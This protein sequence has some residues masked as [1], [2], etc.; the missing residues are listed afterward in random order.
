[1]TN[2]YDFLQ[3]QPTA[4]QGEIETALETR[5]HQ[6]RKLVTHHDPQVANQATQALTVLEQARVTLLDPGKRTAYDTGIGLNSVLGGLADPEAILQKLDAARVLPP[7]PKSPTTQGLVDVLKCPHC[8]N[9]SNP[10]DARF[11]LSCRYPLTQICPNPECKS[12]LPLNYRNC[13]RCGR[14]IEEERRNQ[15]QLTVQAEANLQQEIRGVI[16]QVQALL[17]EKKWRVARE[18]LAC[19]E[20]L[21]VPTN[22]DKQPGPDPIYSQGRPEWQMASELDQSAN[23]MKQGLI[24]SLILWM[25]GVYGILGLIGG[26]IAEPSAPESALF[27]GLFL[28]VAAAIGSGIYAY[29]WSGRYGGTSDYVLGGLAPLVLLLGFWLVIILIVLWFAGIALGGG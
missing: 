29:K 3:V 4:S 13:P 27:I 14:N 22:N 21:G 17:A 7:S 8:G 23:Q 28:A 6:W 5:Y 24:K 9:V 12:E 20:G 26:F 25:A 19:F 10:A 1:M 15:E 2:Y 16:E 11:C 18:N